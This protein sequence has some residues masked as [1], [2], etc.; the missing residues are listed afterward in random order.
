MDSVIWGVKCGDGTDRAASP[1]DFRS[2]SKLESRSSYTCDMITDEEE[3]SR[4][5]AFHACAGGM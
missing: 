4:F 5:H 1:T 3:F 2:E